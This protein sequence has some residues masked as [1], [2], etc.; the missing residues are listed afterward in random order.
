MATITI[1][2]T[3]LDGNLGD[4]WRDNAKTAD[5]LAEYMVEAWTKDL[6]S[7]SAHGHEV[8]I[9]ITVEYHTSGCSSP[10]IVEVD[11]DDISEDEIERSLTPDNILWRKFCRSDEARQL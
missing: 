10:V 9:E 3:I 8:V 2:N 4:G 7:F 5:A 6:E 1:T 11:D